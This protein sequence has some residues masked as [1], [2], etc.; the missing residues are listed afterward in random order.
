MKAFLHLYAEPSSPTLTLDELATWALELLPTLRIDLRPPFL[1]GYLEALSPMEQEAALDRLAVGWGQARVRNPAQPFV[2]AEPLYGEVAYE[3]RRLTNPQS[4]AFGVFYDGEFIQLL[5]RDLIG[6]AEADLGHI[7]VI[8]TN[9]LLGT[10]DESDRRYHARTS[11]YGVPNLISTN[12]L[13]EAPAKPREYYLLKQQYAALGM[14]DA[15][16]ILETEF[17][18]RVVAPDDP[19]LT[20]IMKGYLMQSIFYH[21]TGDPFCPD[22]YCRL[23]NAHWQEE[24]IRAQLGGSYQF[25]PTHQAILEGWR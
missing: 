25:C 15:A 3:R 22:P 17:E 13:V 5:L 4:R 18:G 2:A 24:V 8:F 20:E 14:G 23:F 6:K 1:A 7:H 19:R 21:L 16:A 11:L 12:G 10:F 9:Q